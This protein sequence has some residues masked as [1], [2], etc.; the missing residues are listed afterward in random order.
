MASASDTLTTAPA[1]GAP[2]SGAGIG[3]AARFAVRELRGGLRGFGVFL[4]C[5]ILGVAAIAGVGSVARG[6]TDGLAREGRA[7]L[8]GDLAVRLLQRD[9]SPEE[10]AY[11]QDLGT[12]SEV[13]TLR[14]IARTA[15][16]EGQ[17]LVELK[18]VDDP[19]PLVGALSVEGGGDADALIAVDDNGVYG[20]L[21]EIEFLA[22]AGAEAGDVLRLGETQ[23][24]LRG[25]I[26]SEPDRLSD[27]FS[28]GP[29]LLIHRNALDA[30]GL[31]QPGSLTNWHY[32]VLMP[33]S[34]DEATVEAAAER[35][36]QDFPESAWRISTR[37]EAAPALNR[38]IQRFAEFLTLIGLTALII[39]GVGVANAVS[40]FLEGKRDVIATLKC[41]GAPSGL[42]VAVYL[43]EIMIIAGFG[44]AAGLVLG[45]AIPFVAGSLLAQFVPIA[46]DGIYPFE[47]IL[48]AI[49]G[50]LTALAFAL[51]PLGRSR[52]VSPTDLF[53]DQVAPA[54]RRPPTGYLIAVGVTLVVLAALAIGLAFD[55]RIAAVFVGGAAGAFVL[56]RIVGWAV[57][58]LARRMPRSKS[59]VVRLAVGSIH[60][61][62]ALTPAV[63]LSLGL[64]LTLLVA[65]VL[66]DG[67]FRREL[68]GTI[69][70]TAP[71]FFILDIQGDEGPGLETFVA[72][73][74][75]EASLEMQ[76]MLRGRI[77]HLAGVPAG[78]AEIDPDA[79]WVLQGD[80]GI[81]YAETKPDNNDL[82]AGE[83]WPVEYDGPPLVSF[84]DE[85]GRE[86]RLDL[87]D[88]IT[89]NVLGREITAE[90]ASFR[91]INWQSLRMNSVMIFSPNTLRGAPFTSLATLSYPDGGTTETELAFLKS[92]VDA[93]P[94]ITVIRVKE[95]IET[96]NG[97]V[98]QIGWAVR[99][100]SGITLTASMLVLGGAFAAGRRRR[101]HD[102]VVL[103]TLGATR[104]KLIGAYSLEFL[105]LGA[106]T[107]VF[108]LIA[109]SVA[110]WF[111]LTAIMDIPFAFLLVPA[112]GAAAVA[113]AL[114]LI[115]GLAGTWRVL[116]Q[117]AAPIL[118][119]L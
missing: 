105:L 17:A 86:L 87:G 6:M 69:P 56:L 64:G 61:P 23:I 50:F 37:S 12:L 73:N 78:E 116:G 77:T 80:R 88:T 106:A 99:G 32:R 102:A 84:G 97:I 85:V 114:T 108:G 83:W 7:I 59:T 82:T 71:S 79:R 21:A 101:I 52:Q 60:R 119:N 89:V 9:A 96:A 36:A 67:N 51:Y 33:G 24:V 57:M 38:N 54:T 65:L 72:E 81:T 107:T 103:K 48:A 104:G 27:G 76:P 44:I 70:Q 19:Y 3:L 18:A 75:P 90:I 11:L 39:G 111:V 49:Y 109:G 43:I 47:L 118:R 55:R 14:A 68:F 10:R 117:K 46:I 98:E 8:G 13:A 30:T 74:A 25:V 115:F 95:A 45:A 62:G 20:G 29:R 26:E 2:P 22:R 112:V 63:V 4:A 110:A 1:A 15:D 91:T 66:I 34:P 100:A 16:G 58:A 5:I 94:A 93:F 31:V 92:V 42:P 53:R 41:L 113:L 40:S 28:I 35:L